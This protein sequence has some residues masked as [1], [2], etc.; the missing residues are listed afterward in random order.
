MAVIKNIDDEL[1]IAWNNFNVYDLKLV[2]EQFAVARL[3]ISTDMID[4][5]L[6][7]FVFRPVQYDDNGITKIGYGFTTEINRTGGYTEDE[8]FTRWL[9]ELKNKEKI[10]KKQTSQYKF[11]QTQYDSL[12]SLFY[13]LGN[14]QNIPADT[15]ADK[16]DILYNV[17]NNNWRQIADMIGRSRVNPDQRLQEA[18]ILMLA[19]YIKNFDRKSLK[20]EGFKFLVSQYKNFA[21]NVKT[22]ADN[23]YYREFGKFFDG[24]DDNQKTRII[25]ANK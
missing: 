7:N 8:A 10:F 19:N 16:F 24:V 1:K 20:N 2:S 11:S 23:V 5:I 18:R 13:F 4:I 9:L 14:W 3:K 6:A 15:E 21:G 22:Q 12:F 17:K 25:E